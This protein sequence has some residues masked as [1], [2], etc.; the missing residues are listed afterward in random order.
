M[1]GCYPAGGP[2]CRPCAPA[3]APGPRWAVGGRRTSVGGRTVGAGSVFPH[4]AL[5]RATR[6]SDS[7]DPQDLAEALDSD[8]LPGDH[9]DPDVEP[10][11]PLDVP[12][13]VDEYGLTSA[14]EQFDE[15]LEERV[16]R[17]SPDP[18]VV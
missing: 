15:P 17:E 4:R 1:R 18:L 8:K 16:R 5:G 6:M 12:I 9:D 14:E 2:I 3:R 13:G 10:E 11:Y 7:S